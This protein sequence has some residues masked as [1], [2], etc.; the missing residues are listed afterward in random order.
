MSGIRFNGGDKVRISRF[1]GVCTEL[2][3][4]YICYTQSITNSSGIHFINNNNEL[5]LYLM[6]LT[7]NQI[8]INLIKF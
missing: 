6:V 5:V 8:I 2:V 7:N 3:K 1:K 4:W